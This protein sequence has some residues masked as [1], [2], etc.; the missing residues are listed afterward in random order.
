MRKH[1]IIWLT[2]GGSC[3]RGNRPPAE[4]QTTCGGIKTRETSAIHHELANR[5][6]T[7]QMDPQPCLVKQV[8]KTL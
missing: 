2:V 3:Q 7:V 4:L 5:E 8:L 1:L 6:I